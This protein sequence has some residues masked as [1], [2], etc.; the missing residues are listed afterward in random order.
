[1]NVEKSSYGFTDTQI[2]SLFFIHKVKVSFSVAV[3][4]RS[5]NNWRACV[6][7]MITLLCV[8]LH[9]GNECIGWR[10]LETWQTQYL[11]YLELDSNHLFLCVCVL[12]CVATSDGTLYETKCEKGTWWPVLFSLTLSFSAFQR[13]NGE[14]LTA[15]SVK[16]LSHW[17]F[18]VSF[19]LDNVQRTDQDLY[20]CVTQSP[21]GSGVSN[22]AELVVKGE[23][24]RFFVSY[25]SLLLFLVFL[26]CQLSV[27]LLILW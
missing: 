17:R 18:V 26:T 5:V 12:L 6:T 16:H 10:S 2:M 8:E 27:S 7:L 25:C 3:E 19:Q 22:F 1:M 11:I 20:R 23:H 13:H 24:S 14:I 15:A 21:R 9:Y 4:A